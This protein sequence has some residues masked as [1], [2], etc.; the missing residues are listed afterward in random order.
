MSTASPQPPPAP[1]APAEPLVDPSTVLLVAIVVV[2]LWAG[3]AWGAWT[4]PLVIGIRRW[5]GVSPSLFKHRRGSGGS[6]DDDDDDLASEPLS[7]RAGILLTVF[8][9]C[10]LLAIYFFPSVLVYVIIL[11]FWLSGV[12]CL[13]MCMDAALRA[14]KLQLPAFLKDPVFPQKKRASPATSDPPAAADADAGP[15]E[16][17]DDYLSWGEAILT[18]IAAAIT[19]FW[20]V[21]RNSDWAWIL[22]DLLGMCLIITSFRFAHFPNTMVAAFILCALFVYD[23]FWVFGS[24]RF[25][26]DGTS[27]MESVARAVGTTESMP[28][29]FR[30]P[31]MMGAGKGYSMLG[32]GDLIVPGLLLHLARA[33]DLAHWIAYSGPGAYAL[34][35]A[36]SSDAQALGSG[37]DAPNG[38]S[39]VGEASVHPDAA[40]SARHRRNASR[41]PA[42]EDSDAGDVGEPSVSAGV[43]AKAESEET[44]LLA[45]GGKSEADKPIAID[46]RTFPFVNPAPPRYF[47]ITMAGYLVGFAV[48]LAVVQITHAAQ[49]ALLYLVPGTLLPFVAHAAARGELRAVWSG[50][51]EWEWAKPE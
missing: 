26:R 41:N 7:I 13:V 44:P 12:S 20:L 35:N 33:L 31:K 47:A 32:F 6:D 3:A 2:T 42:S 45:D 29:L 9:S 22:Q 50:V 49:P 5:P 51:S 36:P 14:T 19:T 28:V 38:P 8:S 4:H 1:P 37:A 17:P 24:A 46:R 40:G 39:V 16:P 27:V 21:N 11:S 23:V 48:T 15:S 18:L 25:T 43:A 30:V 10:S 34:R